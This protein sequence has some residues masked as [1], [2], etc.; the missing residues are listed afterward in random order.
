MCLY[1]G[2][3]IL[4]CK[5]ISYIEH[6]KLLGTTGLC[7]LIQPVKLGLLAAVYTYT[8]YFVIKIF[9]KP[10]DDGCSVKT[11]GISKNDFFLHDKLPP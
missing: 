3:D 6:V 7:S 2:N 11:T 4:V 9:L 5:F 10:G 1:T 8:D